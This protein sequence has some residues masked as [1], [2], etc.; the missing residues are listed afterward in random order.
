[1]LGQLEQRDGGRWQL[2]FT[3]RFTH[4]PEKVWRA[5]T[6]PEHL[7]VWFPTDIEGE[8]R[9]GAPLRFVFRRGEGPPVDGEMLAYDPPSLME[10]RWGDETLRFEL[11]PDGGG[12]VLTFVNA[13]AERGKAARDAAGWHACLDVLAHRL[14]GRP[15]PWEPGQRW[16]EVHPEYVARFGPE[17]STIGRPATPN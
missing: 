6:E 12:S 2:R 13:F 15:A 14:D 16:A 7:A 9:A 10:L 5:L 11:R 3:R 17:A 8:R 4:P 1:M